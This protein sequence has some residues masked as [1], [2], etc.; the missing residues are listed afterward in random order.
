MT[1]QVLR[2][3]MAG[4][5]GTAIHYATLVALVRFA[6]VS[7]VA[8]STVGAV[9]GA[10]VNYGVNHRWTFDSERSHSH[11]LP[12]FAGVALAALAVNALALSAMLQ[13]VG[14]HYLVAQTVATGVVFFLAYFVNRTWTF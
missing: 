6:Q 1:A 12:R 3:G 14:A 2:Y 13:F 9:A 4:T 11:A 10:I 8:A 7:A 5:F